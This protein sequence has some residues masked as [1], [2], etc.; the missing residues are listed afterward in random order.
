MGFKLKKVNDKQY[1]Y[2]QP[3]SISP[4]ARVFEVFKEEQA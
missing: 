4:K 3:Q 1:I 2:E